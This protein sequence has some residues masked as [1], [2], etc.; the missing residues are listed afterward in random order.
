MV[1]GALLDDGHGVVKVSAVVVDFSN[2]RHQAV[3]AASDKDLAGVDRHDVR[4]LEAVLVDD[5]HALVVARILLAEDGPVV[6][7]EGGLVAAVVP[8]GGVSEGLA[9]CQLLFGQDAEH[10]VVGLSGQLVPVVGLI[11][12]PLFGLTDGAADEHQ[13][14]DEAQP[15]SPAVHVCEITASL[16]RTKQ[17]YLNAESGRSN[18]KKMFVILFGVVGGA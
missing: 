4:M 10:E 16:L 11:S 15:Q 12:L 3:V 2:D 7:A 18:F 6:A 13:A 5:P 9:F 14:A 1:H 8:G 17:F